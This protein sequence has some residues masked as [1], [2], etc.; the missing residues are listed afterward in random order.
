M[1]GRRLCWRTV[2]TCR[3]PYV[4]RNTCCY[5][6]SHARQCDSPCRKVNIISV[7]AAKLHAPW[8]PEI[9]LRRVPDRPRRRRQPRPAARPAFARQRHLPAELISASLVPVSS[10]LSSSHSGL[11]R[12]ATT[13]CPS[14]SATTRPK[15][16]TSTRSG[17]MKNKN[18]QTKFPVV[19]PHCRCAMS[20][21]YR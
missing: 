16:E 12:P 14:S 20:G 9:R 15:V 5:P 1:C 18:K 10:L 2:R 8:P 21:R 13:A 4:G 19:R 11:S 7:F 3:T 6:P 17:A